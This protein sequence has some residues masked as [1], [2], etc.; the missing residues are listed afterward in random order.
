MGRPH[1][2]QHQRGVGEERRVAGGPTQLTDEQSGV[3]KGDGGERQSAPH[4]LG[5]PNLWGRRRSGSW[6]EVWRR[7]GGAPATHLVLHLR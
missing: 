3:E 4:S 6:R 1:S 7:Q 2:P 5:L